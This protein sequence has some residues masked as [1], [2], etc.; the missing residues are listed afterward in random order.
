M[1]D[2]HYKNKDIIFS[3]YSEYGK[4][5]KSSSNYIRSVEEARM[6]LA[7]ENSTFKSKK[8]E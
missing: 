3:C 1:E 2:E 5:N 6:M 7:L 8:F 4:K